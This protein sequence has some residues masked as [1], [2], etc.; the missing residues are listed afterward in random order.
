MKKDIFIIG[1]LTLIL[2]LIWEFSHYQLYL[3]LSGIPKF[4]HLIL[5]SFTDMF[6]LLCILG[7]IS[8]KNK[9]FNWI[10]KPN[11]FDYLFVLILG[12]F[13]ALSIELINLNLGRWSYTPEMPTLL[14]I[15]LSPLIQLSLTGI[16]SL[17]IFSFLS[18]RISP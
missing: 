2:N 8:L 16:I 5:A 3:D 18:S 7:L 6:I 10:K 11:K 13:I 17:F 14:G 15:G 1:F 4:P 12:L 9:N